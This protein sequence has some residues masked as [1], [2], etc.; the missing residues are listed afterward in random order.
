MISWS[1]ILLLSEGMD[2]VINLCLLKGFDHVVAECS[3]Q[4]GVIT[5]HASGNGQ[6]TGCNVLLE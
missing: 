6:H 5:V 2:L 1:E 4:G 3:N